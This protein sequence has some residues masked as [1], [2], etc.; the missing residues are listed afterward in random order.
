MWG[1]GSRKM[2]LEMS[3]EQKEDGLR[4]RAGARYSE[5][6]LGKCP[7]AEKDKQQ[8]LGDLETLPGG[9]RLK[10]AL[11]KLM[12]ERKKLEVL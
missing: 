8:I 6:R 3:P 5:V 11:L 4:L 2:A 1:V 12:R 7:G 10:P 9:W